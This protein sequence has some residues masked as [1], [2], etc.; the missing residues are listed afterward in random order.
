MPV[1][2]SRRGSP[3]RREVRAA[4][5]GARTAAEFLDRLRGN[6][7]LVRE[8]LSERDP[9]Q[10]T[11]YAVAW[12]GDRDR[13]GAPVWYGGGKLAADLSLPKLLTRWQ[14]LDGQ[15]RRTG[16]GRPRGQRT[17]PTD[18]QHG[19]LG[20]AEHA[21]LWERAARTAAAATEHV[22][23][24]AGTDPD[25]A[26]DAAHAAGEALTAA[27]RLAEGVRGGPLT[28]AADRYDRAARD[29]W[30]RA[31][32]R[33]RTGTDLR[34]TARFLTVAACAPT[35]QR[36]QLLALLTNLAA[37]VDAVAALRDTQQR[38]AQASAA[39]DAAHQ[40][41]S[42]AVSPGRVRTDPLRS[43]SARRPPRTAAPR[44]PCAAARAP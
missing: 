30:G 28:A 32:R 37:L 43:H 17:A 26:A 11:G 39:R 34:A 42:A 41:R 10:V 20:D 21:D 38:T 19:Q 14:S 12:P 15:P 9:G 5:I 33:T 24:R 44:R 40:L 36:T 16:A 27:A 13:G 18:Q 31:A 8:R 2:G 29:L 1:V 25:G 35:D 22:R 4:A 6:G 7:V 3:L 23:R